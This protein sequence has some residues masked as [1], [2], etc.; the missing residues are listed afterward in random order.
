MCRAWGTWATTVR[1][2]LPKRA[3][4]FVGVAEYEGAISKEDGIDLEALIAFRKET[5]SILNFP[6]AT[7]LP[8]RLDALFLPCDILIPAALEAQIHKDNVDQVKAKIVAEA[9]NG[10]LTAEANDRL[11]E[12]GILIIPDMYLNAG[13]VTV[14]YFEWLKNLSHV[15]FGRMSNRTEAQAKTEILKTVEVMTGKSIDSETF[16]RIATGADEH[17]LVRSGLE[18]TM[19]FAYNEIREIRN[20]HGA[21]VD[22]RTA[23]FISAIDKVAV[24]YLSM[25]IFP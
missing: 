20:H 14:S 12:R 9:A 17:T 2:F 1:G 22:L 18:E 25:G 11:L 5:G 13:G 7:N 8:D 23:A 24:S 21:D 10:P 15:R 3:P 16:K 6:G 19:V 4:R